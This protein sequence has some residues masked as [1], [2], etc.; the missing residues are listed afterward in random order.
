MS[1][2]APS[3]GTP[4]INCWP[5][6]SPRSWPGSSAVPRARGRPTE[7]DLVGRVVTNYTCTHLC[8]CN[9]YSSRGSALQTVGGQSVP[10]S[11]LAQDSAFS[12]SLPTIPDTASPGRSGA[13]RRRPV[14]SG[15]GAPEAAQEA[16]RCSFCADTLLWPRQLN[17]LTVLRR[18]LEPAAAQR[19]RG[20][21]SRRT[22][23]SAWPLTCSS[24]TPGNC[25]AAPRTSCGG[26]LAWGT[27][28]RGRRISIS[29]ARAACAG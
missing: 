8:M 14:T 18:G 23:S 5:S 4:S 25:R 19:V 9:W 16:A 24:P 15:S 6:T 10:E 22:R 26:H 3:F 27:D 7:E 13:L 28:G 20:S 12:H 17:E 1:Q 29:R 2:V 21:G 11:V